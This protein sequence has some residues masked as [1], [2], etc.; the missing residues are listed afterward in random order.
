MQMN[1]RTLLMAS[2]VLLS[3]SASGVAAPIYS[4][5]FDDAASA[6]LAQVW[7]GTASTTY[8][9]GWSSLNAGG[10]SPGSGSLALTLGLNT[11]VDG[12]SDGAFTVDIPGA[13]GQSFSSWSFDLQVD[14][15]SAGDAYGGFG[16]LQAVT[17]NPGYN[18]VYAEEMGN[19]AYGPTNLAGTWEHISIALDPSTGS[20]LSQLAFFLIGPPGGNLNGNVTFYIDNIVLVPEP[21]TGVLMALGGMLPFVRRGRRLK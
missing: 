1:R 11:A 3:L 18:D 13:A 6:S 19:P 10:G 5:T 7:F 8:S 12:V 21:S 9:I 16:Y 14:P 4:Y 17:L 2:T 15:A 20:N